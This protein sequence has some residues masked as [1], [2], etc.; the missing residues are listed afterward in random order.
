MSDE[1]V[2]EHC[3]LSVRRE[4]AFGHAFAFTLRTDHFTSGR[5]SSHRTPVSS[6]RRGHHS[7]GTRVTDHWYTTAGLLSPSFLD[8]AL[9][10]PA[11]LIAYL[12]AAAES[13]LPIPHSRRRRAIVQEN[14]FCSASV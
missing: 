5:R 9:A 8:S 2:H 10:P 12:V 14:L 1:P 4:L 3:Q 13:F 6:S 7:A 11:S